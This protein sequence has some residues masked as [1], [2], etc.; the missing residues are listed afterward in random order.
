DAVLRRHR[1]HHVFHGARRRRLRRA[2][3]MDGR[4]R[5]R[6]RRVVR[7][8]MRSCRARRHGRR[9]ER[10]ARRPRLRV[11]AAVRIALTFNEKHTTTETDAEFDSRESIA[12]VARIVEALG[13]VV[14]PI[15]VSGPLPELVA[16][17]ERAAP[18]RVFNFAEGTRG[19]FR[20]AFYPAL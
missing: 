8:R 12:A 17:L 2:F 9:L 20:E 5:R 10:N 1:R 6:G 13:H 3:G 11:G 14:M 19:T 7:A 18:D 15:E 16:A 4:V